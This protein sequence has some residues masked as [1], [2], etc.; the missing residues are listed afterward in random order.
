MTVIPLPNAPERVE[1]REHTIASLD[2]AMEMIRGAEALGF[3]VEFKNRTVWQ[4]NPYADDVDETEGTT[5]YD[6]TIFDLPL[7]QTL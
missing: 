5:L 3:G 4:E 6:V 2:E 1:I 7:E